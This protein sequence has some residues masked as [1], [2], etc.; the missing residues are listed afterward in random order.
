M[1]KKIFFTLITFIFSFSL[2][3]QTGIVRGNLID[4]DFQDPVPFA[5]I[6][7]KETGTG[8]TSDFDGN[9]E[10][11]LSEGVYTIIFSFIGYE[12]VEVQDVAINSEEPTI[13]N[14]TMNTLAQGLDEV[15]VSVSASTNTEKS[16]LEF[17]KKSISL[18]DG[19]SSQRIK[20]SGASNIAS[21]V[22]SVPGVSVQGGKYVYVRG[23]GDR[24]TKS[25]QKKKTKSMTTAL[26]VL[27]GIILETITVT[28]YCT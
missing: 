12:T 11:V 27:L 24:Y 17:Q 25:I 3:A 23:L 21:A 2:Q 10:L 9:Y 19:L 20:S 22:K 13:V 5:N 15:V 16:V 1:K 28:C 8:T 14:V 26:C 18:V 7:V 6:I 4:N